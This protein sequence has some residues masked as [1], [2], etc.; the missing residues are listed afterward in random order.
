MGSMGF[1]GVE[2]E[3][4]GSLSPKPPCKIRTLTI[5]PASTKG[6]A[7]EGVVRFKGSGLHGG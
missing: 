4:F 2:S 6:A 5:K 3:G 1:R 7:L